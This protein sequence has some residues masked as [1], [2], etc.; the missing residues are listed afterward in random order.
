MRRFVTGLGRVERAVPPAALRQQIRRQVA[1]SRRLWRCGRLSI[2]SACC[3]SPSSRRCAP[4][5]AMVLALM[6]GL[7]T[8]QSPGREPDA[9]A[10]AAGPAGDRHRPGRRADVPAYTTSEVAG[11]EFI[12]TEAA[13]SSGGWRGKTPEA[14]VDAGSPQGR[15][16]LTRYSDLEFLLADGSPVVLRYNLETVEIHKLPPTRELGFEEQ[17]VVHVHGRTVTTARLGG[18]LRPDHRGVPGEGSEVCLYRPQRLDRSR[19]SSSSRR[20]GS[21]SSPGFCAQQLLARSDS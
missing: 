18:G 3:S 5:L 8:P 17:P 20:R 14:R 21:S 19:R 4:P 9:A 16:L 13:G 7:V 11:R 10:D 15:A 2:R 12:W 1:R 6:V